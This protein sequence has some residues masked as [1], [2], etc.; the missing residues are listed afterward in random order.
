MHAICVCVCVCVCVCLEEEGVH[1][2]MV[3]MTDG[4]KAEWNESGWSWL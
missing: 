4:F 1:L 2:C 3:V